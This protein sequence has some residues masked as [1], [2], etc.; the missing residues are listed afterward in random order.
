[1]CLADS[2]FIYPLSPPRTLQSINRSAAGS[3]SRRFNPS[4]VFAPIRSLAFRHKNT[5][6]WIHLIRCI[7]LLPYIADS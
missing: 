5:G 7:A 4:K 1:M 3:N 6:L 2:E